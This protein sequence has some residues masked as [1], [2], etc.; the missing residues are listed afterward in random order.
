MD[1]PFSLE[2]SLESLETYWRRRR[3]R[4]VLLSIGQATL[5]VL[6]LLWICSLFDDSITV[7]C[8]V[9]PATLPLVEVIATR[10]QYLR[11]GFVI[12]RA[13][14]AARRWSASA[15]DAGLV[16]RYP[17][18]VVSVARDRI[19]SATLLFDGHPDTTDTALTDVLLVHVSLEPLS[20]RPEPATHYR[21]E[22]PGSPASG[23]R[24]LTLPATAT[25][26]PEVL[27]W[28]EAEV[29]VAQQDGSR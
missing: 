3:A 15:S 2:Q 10:L 29:P 28:L 19:H 8:L 23:L 11:A 27:R 14:R 26:Y 1:Q 25:G 20:P 16:F 9:A 7:F 13:A 5:L 18:G 4:Y 24:R 12:S 22:P 21:A 6:V 17:G